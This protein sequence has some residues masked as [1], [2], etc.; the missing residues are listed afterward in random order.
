MDDQFPTLVTRPLDPGLQVIGRL[1]RP[2]DRPLSRLTTLFV[3]D[4][5][6]VVQDLVERGV[7]HTL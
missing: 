6:T 4:L 1:F 3:A 2:R 5:E 7:I